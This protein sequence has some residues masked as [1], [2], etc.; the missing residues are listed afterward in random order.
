MLWRT[1]HAL[2]FSCAA[3]PLSLPRSPPG[4]SGLAAPGRT[5]GPRRARSSR[6]SPSPTSR[7]CPYGTTTARPRARRAGGPRSTPARAPKGRPTARA[8]T[9]SRARFPA[10][11]ARRP[12]GK[13]PRC[14]CTPAGS[15]RTR[16]AAE[17]T[18]SCC[19][20][21]GPL[22]GARGKHAQPPA[23]M[24]TPE[25]G[26][27][28]PFAPNSTAATATTPRRASRCRATR[29]SRPPTSSP[30]RASTRLASVVRDD[31]PH[32]CREY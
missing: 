27:S 14:T 4:T 17:T 12:W 13:T 24:P 10:A 32:P 6:P 11:R 7:T 22:S 5:C 2:A 21:I 8:L 29:A 26:P 31:S 3:A 19:E 15:S 1:A 18:S 30:R 23:R 20:P 16:S 28:S 25:S 9:R